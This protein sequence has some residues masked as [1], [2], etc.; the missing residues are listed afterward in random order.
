MNVNVNLYFISF[1]EVEFSASHG[2]QATIEN[3][4][5]N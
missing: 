2:S 1:L 3:N 5:E 4:Q